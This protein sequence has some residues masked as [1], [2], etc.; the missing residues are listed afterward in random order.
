MARPRL[1]NM[2]A[3]IPIKASCPSGFRMN[4][5]MACSTP[6][7]GRPKNPPW[8]VQSE[9]NTQNPSNREEGPVENP[10][11]RGLSRFCPSL[12][13]SWP[14]VRVLTSG[15]AEAALQGPQVR[16]LASGSPEAALQGH[17]CRRSYPPPSH[18]YWLF[19][20]LAG[21]V[22]VSTFRLWCT[23]LANML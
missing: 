12:W 22:A 13:R 20:I 4:T 19:L 11:Q 9:M 2:S 14:Q 8:S 18:V 21:S 5:S 15:S 1:Y 17:R 10:A 16:V 23:L 3:G 6:A 7:L